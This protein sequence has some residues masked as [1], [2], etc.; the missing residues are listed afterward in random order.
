[1]RPEELT[2]GQFV[3]VT[4]LLFGVEGE[5]WATNKLGNKEKFQRAEELGEHLSN[6][7]NDRQHNQ[8]EPVVHNKS[9][10]NDNKTDQQC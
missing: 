5:D 1:M 3:E 6:P 2:P 7:N 9:E 4:R 10:R 8:N